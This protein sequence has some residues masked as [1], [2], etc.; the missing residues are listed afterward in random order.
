MSRDTRLFADFTI[1]G[2]ELEFD[3]QNGDGK[4]CEALAVVFLED[5]GEQDIHRKPEYKPQSVRVGRTT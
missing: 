3:V 4:N 1:E 5:D 2:G